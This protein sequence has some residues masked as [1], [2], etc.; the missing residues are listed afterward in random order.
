MQLLIRAE[1]IKYLLVSSWPNLASFGQTM[2][3]IWTPKSGKEAL[4]PG[5]IS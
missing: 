1:V 4:L 3:T 5:W 2:D